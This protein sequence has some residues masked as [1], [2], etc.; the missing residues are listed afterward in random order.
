M[1]DC[2]KYIEMISSMVD[3]E[4][5][6]EQEAELRAHIETCPD[7]RRVFDAFS[8]ISS[9]LSDDLEEPP[10]ALAK[11]VMFRIRGISGGKRPR[12]FIFGRFTAIAA[13]IALLLIAGAKY[14]WFGIGSDTSGDATMESLQTSDSCNGDTTSGSSASDGSTTGNDEMTFESSP[15]DSPE[16][17]SDTGEAD[18]ETGT[19][20]GDSAYYPAD[21]PNLG[22]SDDSSTGKMDVSS[23][24][25]RLD[26]LFSTDGIKLYG[27]DVYDEPAEVSEDDTAGLSGLLSCVSIEE[28]SAFNSSVSPDYT[29]VFSDDTSLFVRCADDGSLYCILEGTCYRAA[30]TAAD[31]REYADDILG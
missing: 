29:L 21:V 6:P 22:L 20:D 19:D 4:L 12:R 3:G 13:C 7:C 31:F 23:V 17:D 2:E 27:E 5:S 8:N 24:K 10:E 15:S 28:T 18:D 11:G 9:A 14:D 1:A 26:E 16:T 30:G 25:D